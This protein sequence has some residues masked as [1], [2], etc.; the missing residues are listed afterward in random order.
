MNSN[1]VYAGDDIK[2]SDYNNIRLDGGQ[3]GIIT[4]FAGA[5]APAGWFIC[6]GASKDTTT[7][8]D[9]FAV[10]G[11]TFGG[12]GAN[13]SLPDLRDKFAIG[14][15][16]TKALGSAGGSNTITLSE[17]NIPTHSHSISSDGDHLHSFNFSDGFGASQHRIVRIANLNNTDTNIATTHTP[18]SWQSAHH[19]ATA[20]AGSGTAFSALPNYIALNYIIKY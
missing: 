16:G 12:S 15:S 9:L 13:F 7:Y 5:T 20:G 3:S 8:A 6:D 2:A 1:T 4:F 17:A 11:Y 14:K 18:T 19:T 10:I